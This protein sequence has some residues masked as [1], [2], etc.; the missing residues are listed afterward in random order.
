MK[1]ITLRIPAVEAAM[2]QEVQKTHKAF[3]NLEVLVLDLIR[4]KYGKT[5]VGKTPK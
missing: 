4:E 1:T 3:C 2:L 5:P